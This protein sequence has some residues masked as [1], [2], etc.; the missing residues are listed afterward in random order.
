MIPKPK[1]PEDESQVVG[2][3]RETGKQV[4]EAR[5]DINEAWQFSDSGVLDAIA[6]TELDRVTDALVKLLA[7]WD[8]IAEKNLT[9]AISKAGTA[10]EIATKSALHIWDELTSSAY[11]DTVR[12]LGKKLR[13][14]QADLTKAS[15]LKKDG[16]KHRR[17]A[18]ILY[19]QDDYAA[20]KDYR[21]AVKLLRESKEEA[22]LAKFSV[23]GR[24]L[25]TW[26]QIL[27]FLLTV[28]AAAV[29]IIITIRGCGAESQ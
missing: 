18:V 21:K 15:Q 9:N 29:T 10:E 28:I 27:L 11:D 19:E 2:Y 14:S 7:A 23:S 12:A 8:D 25:A 22:E 4:I 26:V 1:N 16:E 3:L 24:T 13:I 5:M 6:A 20:I 17:S